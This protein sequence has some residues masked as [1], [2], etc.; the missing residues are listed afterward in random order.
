MNSQE[1]NLRAEYAQIQE[2][3][4]HPDVFGRTDYPKLAK[5]QAELARIIDLFNEKQAIDEQ[6]TEAKVAC[7]RRRPGI[8]RTRKIRN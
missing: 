7:R 8:S 1:Q 5:R 3:M 2:Q 4:E 6:L